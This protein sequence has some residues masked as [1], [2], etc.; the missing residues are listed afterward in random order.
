MDIF[1]NDF[2][3]SNSIGH[4]VNIVA[5]KMKFEL[6][7]SFINNGYDI[8]AQQWMILSIVYENE[9]INQNELALK[10]K[11]DKTNIARIVDKLKNK[12]YIERISS[13]ND[14]RAFNVFTTILGKSTKEQLSKLAMDVIHNSTKNISLEEQTI[15][16]NVLKKIYTNLS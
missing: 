8:T 11:K 14:K 6:E 13:T 5:N 3:L 4:I 12:N 15:C 10:S 2:K 7:Q 16:M 1:I 9:G